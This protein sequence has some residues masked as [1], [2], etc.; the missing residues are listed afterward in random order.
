MKSKSQKN[1]LMKFK[2]EVGQ[3]LELMLAYK[4]ER[5]VIKERIKAIKK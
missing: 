5:E 1:T 2:K 3:K 4:K